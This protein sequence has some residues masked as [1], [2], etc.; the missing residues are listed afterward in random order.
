MTDFDVILEKLDAMG[1]KVDR[2]ETAISMMADQG[3]RI[4]YLTQQ[5]ERMWKW[6]NHTETRV[7]SIEKFQAS[8]PRESFKDVVARQWTVI[9]LIVTA[10]LGGFGLMG[11]FIRWGGA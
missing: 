9:G 4:D 7:S 3:T 10:M 6:T 2:M 5:A 8:C 1:K 11:A